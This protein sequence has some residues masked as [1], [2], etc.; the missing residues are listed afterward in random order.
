MVAAAC[1]SVAAE[2]D[3]DAAGEAAWDVAEDAAGLAAVPLPAPVGAVG[4]AP[5]LAVWRM[6]GWLKGCAMSSPAAAPP[7]STITSRMT[8][9]AADVLERSPSWRR[10]GWRGGPWNGCGGGP[11]G[12]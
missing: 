8:H 11:S 9:R 4:F 5:V 12:G 6:D 10:G 3:V 2:A 1:C 7:P